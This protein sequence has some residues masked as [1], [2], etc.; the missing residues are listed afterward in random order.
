MPALLAYLIAVG[1]LLGGGYGALSWLAA[2]EPVKVVAKVKPK[3]PRYEAGPEAT[4]PDA[5]FSD[6]RSFAIN[7]RDRA[8]SGSNDRPPSSQPGSNAVAKVQ[9]EQA[10]IAGSG[11]DQQTR[12]ANAQVSPPDVKQKAKQPVDAASRTS[13]GNPQTAASAAPVPAAKTVKRPHLRQ[14]NSH[15]DQPAE[16]RALVQMTLRTIEFADGR[17]ATQLVPYRGP[18]HALAFE[19]DE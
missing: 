2:P 11:F 19:P 17:R 12:S 6:A 15:S 18:R 16:R 10:V 8:A 5:S 3:P 9:D 1:L 7:D 4:S 14:A 13:S